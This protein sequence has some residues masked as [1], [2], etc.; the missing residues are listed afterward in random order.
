MLR[1]IFVI[2]LIL[3][4]IIASFY[5]SFNA[6]MF[7]LWVSYFRPESWMWSDFL[8]SL[9]L[10][11][12]VAIFLLVSTIITGVKLR[13]NMFTGL[14]FMA[15]I[16][17]LIST[18]WSNYS[19]IVFSDWIDFI[20]VIIISYLM[21]MLIQS[22]KYLKITLI[23][24][25][26]SLGLEGAKQGWAQLIL[27]PGGVNNNTLPGIGDNNHVAIAM[28]MLVPLLFALY[29]TTERKLF[30]YGFAFLAI[31]VIYRALSTY[32]RGGFLAFSVMCFIFW[33]RSKHKVRTLFIIVII[34]ALLLPVFPQQF[35]DRMNTITV[36]EGEERE[37]SSASRIYFWKVA[38]EMAKTSPVFGVGHNAYKQAY[39]TF[40]YSKGLYGT[41]RAVHSTWF[42]VLSEWGIVGFILFLTIFI[43]SLSL[44]AKTRSGCKSNSKLVSLGI[45]NNSIETSLVTSA[46]GNTFLSGQYFEMLWHYFALAVV[47]NQIFNM[48]N[49]NLNEM[50]SK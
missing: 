44:C 16:H 35:W 36:D 13:F 37:A 28:L 31:G 5:G 18:L 42:A 15:A 14:L 26:L 43:Y 30:K 4:G 17:S 49:D 47:C 1:T 27:N 12:F 24:I 34:S 2:I 29:Q 3:I 46:V 50:R 23:V 22:E 40:D 21:T 41:G 7:Y 25:T 9:R 33:L 8:M 10:S 11:L 39:D 6:L 32:S 45:F 38:W 48:N 20:K 19:T